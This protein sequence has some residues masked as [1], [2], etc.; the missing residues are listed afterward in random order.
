MEMYVQ[1][2]LQCE[3]KCLIKKRRKERHLNILITDKSNHYS[4]HHHSHEEDGTC[5]FCQAF[6][7]TDKVPLKKQ[8]TEEKKR[9]L[10]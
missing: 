7:V 9:K 3:S 1:S 5:G 2:R 8:N 6:F 10:K 4:S